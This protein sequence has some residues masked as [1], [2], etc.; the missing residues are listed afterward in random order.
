MPVEWHDIALCQGNPQNGELGFH[1]VYTVPDVKCDRPATLRQI[2]SIKLFYLREF[3]DICESKAHA[4]L[5]CREFSRLSVDLIFKKYPDSVRKLLAQCIAAFILS[6]ASTVKFVV[7][8]SD[9]NFARG[10]ASP[11]VKGAPCFVDIE[12]FSMYLEGCM[13]MNGWTLSAMRSGTFFGPER[14]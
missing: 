14:A 2:E 7:N 11:R 9:R 1:V 8:W 5:S 6:D 12:Q 10:T 13:E 4:L 3:E